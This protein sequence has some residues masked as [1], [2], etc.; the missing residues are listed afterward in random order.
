[1]HK[2]YPIHFNEF[3]STTAMQPS[4]YEYNGKRYPIWYTIVYLNE[5]EKCPRDAMYADC[6]KYGHLNK[7]HTQHTQHTQHI[8]HPKHWLTPIICKV[9]NKI[10]YAENWWRQLTTFETLQEV[11]HNYDDGDN[12]DNG[13]NG[14]DGN[15]IRYGYYGYLQC[16][17]DDDDGYV[18]RDGFDGQY[19]C[20]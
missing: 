20:Y 15:V 10:A 6:Y 8:P 3:K 11:I 9:F 2:L 5:R 16:D 14:D 13:D 12:G 1:M 4:D 17:A 18:I 19:D 7:L